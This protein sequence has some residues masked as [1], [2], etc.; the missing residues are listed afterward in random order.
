M[1]TEYFKTKTE[2][3]NKVFS[4]HAMPKYDKIQHIWQCHARHIRLNT[5]QGH[6]KGVHL[7]HFLQ[8]SHHFNFQMY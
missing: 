5:P 1:H 8:W 7:R 3:T 2:S 4:T 6:Q